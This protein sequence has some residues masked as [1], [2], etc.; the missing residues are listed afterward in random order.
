MAQRRSLVEGHEALSVCFHIFINY[1]N[2]GTDKMFIKFKD[3]KFLGEMANTLDDR[4]MR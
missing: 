4:V 2:D 3:D 1:L